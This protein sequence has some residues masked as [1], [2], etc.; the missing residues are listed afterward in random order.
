MLKDKI[1]AE[2]TEPTDWCHPMRPVPK[3]E[4]N[5][6]R[7]CVDLTRLNHLKKQYPA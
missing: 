3:K 7:L 6:A 2:V 4:S 1:I 5:D